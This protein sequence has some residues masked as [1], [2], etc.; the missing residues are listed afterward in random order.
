MGIGILAVVTMTA[1][2]PKTRFLA[3]RIYPGIT[4]LLEDSVKGGEL[5]PKTMPLNTMHERCLQGLTVLD[6]ARGSVHYWNAL[7]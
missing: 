1:R 3:E 2:K 5:S 4:Q 7:G 6:A